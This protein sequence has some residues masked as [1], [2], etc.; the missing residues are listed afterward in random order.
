MKKII[1]KDTYKIF[2]LN[3]FKFN[4]SIKKIF[5]NLSYEQIYYIIMLTLDKID[6]IVLLNQNLL[7][8]E[9]FINYKNINIYL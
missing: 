6:D 8:N 1:D 5:T 9:L 3:S 7:F 2:G 4:Y